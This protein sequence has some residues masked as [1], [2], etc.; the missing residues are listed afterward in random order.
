MRRR[1]A[2]ITRNSPP[3]PGRYYFLQIP[4]HKHMKSLKTIL[5]TALF[6]SFAAFSQAQARTESIAVAGNCGMCKAKIE[7]AAKEAGAASADWNADSKMLTVKYKTASTNT[8]RIQ[9]KVAAAGYD[10]RD[11]KA[12]D[13]AYDQL[14]GCCRYDRAVLPQ[15]VT[16]AKKTEAS[17]CSKN[18]A[19]GDKKASCCSDDK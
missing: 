11:V 7:K 18:E 4:K 6:I 13:E 3:F 12:T 1:P 17:C 14:H 10:T 15:A 5:F 19:K 16:A 9:Q 2:K 8:A